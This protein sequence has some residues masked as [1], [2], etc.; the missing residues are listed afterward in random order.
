MDMNRKSSNAI[1]KIFRH[2]N[3]I[4]T[5]VN[6]PYPIYVTGFTIVSFQT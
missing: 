2:S 5:H 4:G 3:P 6:L 1:S